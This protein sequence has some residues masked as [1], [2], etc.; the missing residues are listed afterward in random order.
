M[1]SIILERLQTGN[2]LIGTLHEARR[3]IVVCL[4]SS[5]TGFGSWQDC[6]EKAWQAIDKEKARRKQKMREAG[7]PGGDEGDSDRLE[8]EREGLR[9]TV[10]PVEGLKRD[11]GVSFCDRSETASAPAQ[12]L[13]Q[14]PRPRW[15][16]SSLDPNSASHDHESAASGWD[17]DTLYKIVVSHYQKP[18]KFSGC[19]AYGVPWFSFH[20]DVSLSTPRHGQ[21]PAEW[22][23]QDATLRYRMRTRRESDEIKDM[24]TTG[25]KSE[26]KGPIGSISEDKTGSRPENVESVRHR[27]GRKVW[28]VDFRDGSHERMMNF[29]H[30][31][32]HHPSVNVPTLQS[33]RHAAPYTTARHYT[34]NHLHTGASII[35][36]DEARGTGAER[37]REGTSPTGTYCRQERNN[38]TG[39]NQGQDQPTH[40]PAGC[41]SAAPLP[42]PPR[43]PPADA[44][45]SDKSYCAAGQL[46]V[47]FKRACS[48]PPPATAATAPP[49]SPSPSLPPLPTPPPPPPRCLPTNNVND[50]DDVPAPSWRTHIPSLIVVY[51][52]AYL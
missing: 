47:N 21:W 46:K 1:H 35:E 48:V 49:P 11:K 36:S 5:R 29:H 52:H 30:D 27:I 26:D 42:H 15:T 20:C 12:P 34:H 13:A 19:M 7:R 38:G 50:V 3:H 4:C 25:Q 18:N 10:N 6:R 17:F 9:S 8:R 28:P 22:R 43:P 37:Q 2:P 45:L 32:P 31:N 40:T 44:Y 14:P 51:G 16:C 39:R 23:G 24:A 33:A 41:S